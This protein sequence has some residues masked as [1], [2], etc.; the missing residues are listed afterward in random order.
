MEAFNRINVSWETHAV[1]IGE[2]RD[3]VNALGRHH[4]KLNEARG[5]AA[6]WQKTAIDR[7]LP[8]INELGPQ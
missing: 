2:I 7:I 8:F 4:V 3:Y 1:A 6:P 5:F